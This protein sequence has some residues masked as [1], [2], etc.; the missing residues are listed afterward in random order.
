MLCYQVLM[1]LSVWLF[2]GLVLRQFSFALSPTVACVLAFL[3]LSLFST[4]WT[5]RLTPFVAFQWILVALFFLYVPRFL[6]GYAE[7][8]VK[9]FVL[10]VAACLMVE[11]GVAWVQAVR[12]FSVGESALVAVGTLDDTTGVAAAALLLWV[13]GLSAITSRWHLLRWGAMGC[14]LLLIV[15]VGSRSALIGAAVALVAC[16]LKFERGRFAFFLHHRRWAVGLL[17]VI[18]IAG[19]VVLYEA[20]RDSADGRLL[21]W[22]CTGRLI[23]EQPWLGRGKGGFEADYMDCQARYFAV[24]GTDGRAALLADDVFQP[25]SDPLRWLTEYGFVG[26]LPGVVCLVLILRIRLRRRS[27]TDRAAWLLLLSLGTMSLTSY[28]LTYPFVQVAVLGCVAWLMSRRLGV[29]P[30]CAGQER[31]RR[32][33][34]WATGAAVLAVVAC[35]YTAYL[36]GAERQWAVAHERRPIEPL[37]QTLPRYEKLAAPLGSNPAFLYDYAMACSEASLWPRSDSLLRAYR[38]WGWNAETTLLAADNAMIQG[39]TQQADSLFRLAHFMVPV[40]FYPLYRLMLSTEQQGRLSDAQRLARI[41]LHK[42]VKVPSPE[43][44]LMKKEARRVLVGA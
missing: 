37:G 20:K 27:P 8:P 36:Y 2:L 15:W 35:S 13:M 17:A 43:V 24:H 21:I 38:H 22:R 31:T 39:R 41:I 6:S 44:E 9:T 34:L 18:V 11:V 12:A 42:Q 3:A 7:L 1:A 33:A 32:A 5:H 14:A 4:A 25:M 16:C 23:A 28:P 29:A 40:R 10:P 19:G 30:P 26:M